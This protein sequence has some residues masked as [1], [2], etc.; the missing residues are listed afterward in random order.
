M[1]N[2]VAKRVIKFSLTRWTFQD[3]CY[4]TL[5]LKQHFGYLTGNSMSEQKACPDPAMKLK[6]NRIVRALLIVA[7]T[8]SL[9][10]AIIGIAMPVLPTTPFLLLTVACY[11]RSSERLYTWLI[12]NKWFGEYIRNYREGRGVPLKTKVLAVTILW[13][14][15]SVS[16]LF[17][18]PILIVQVLLLGIAIAVS[19]HILRLP[20]YKKKVP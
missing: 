11:C 7:G 12:N 6:K 1:E 9:V 10:F 19:I 3:G 13:A 18:V 5:F 15:I 2:I 4:I 17:L 20:T 14:S 8:I 16:V